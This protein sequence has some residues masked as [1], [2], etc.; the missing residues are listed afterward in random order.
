MLG[1]LKGWLKNRVSELSTGLRCVS[2]VVMEGMRSW[3]LE[4]HML[5]V[6]SAC[7][8]MPP[9]LHNPTEGLGV[10]ENKMLALDGN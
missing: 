2:G 6:S 8:D 3:Y 5:S 7:C 9:P 1:P 4:G 10:S